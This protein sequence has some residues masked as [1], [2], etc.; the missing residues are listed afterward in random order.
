M[1][2]NSTFKCNYCLRHNAIPY[3]EHCETCKSYWEWYKAKKSNNVGFKYWA[4]LKRKNYEDCK[5]QECS[6]RAG[7][8]FY[9]F[10]QPFYENRILCAGC[11]EKVDK[12]KK[13]TD[14]SMY[15]HTCPHCGSPAYIPI[16]GNKV[17]C[18]NCNGRMQ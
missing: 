11:V 6:T 8:M 18:S 4:A 10:G 2:Q 5:C 13:E 15:P 17:N 16:I 14:L 3:T 1:S 9:P 7:L 12:P